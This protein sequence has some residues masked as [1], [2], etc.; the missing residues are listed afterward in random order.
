MYFD[1]D[2]VCMSIQGVRKKAAP[3][4]EFL[5]GIP[6]LKGVLFPDTLYFPVQIIGRLIGVECIDFLLKMILFELID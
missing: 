1:D 4:I 6:Q 3:L 5:V 2:A